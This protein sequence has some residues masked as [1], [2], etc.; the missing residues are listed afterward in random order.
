MTTSGSPPRSLLAHSQMP[1]PGR[2]VF[3]RLVHGQPLRSRLFAGDDDV[4]V[5]STAQ[6]VIR[7]REQAIGIRRQINPNHLRLLVH[8][9]I[10]ETRVLVAESRCGP[11]ARRGMTADS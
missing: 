3:D 1:M 5:I 9:V 6:A 4:Y 11:G 10:D 8:H 2:A 7:H